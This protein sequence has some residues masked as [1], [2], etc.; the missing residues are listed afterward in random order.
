MFLKLRK[1]TYSPLNQITIS[2]KAIIDNYKHVQLLNPNIEIFPVLKSN[3]YG[4]G[5]DMIGDFIDE[6]NSKYICVD[7]IFE[8][9]ELLKL[10]VKTPILIL[11]YVDSSNLKRKKLPFSYAVWD[12]TQ[13][14][15]ILKYQA[16][17]KLHLFI[18]T[19]MH[20]EGVR[21]DELEFLLKE[22]NGYQ[23]NFEGLM[24]HFAS[25]DSIDSNLTQQ[26]LE[27]FEKAISLAKNLGFNFKY[28]HI[29]ASAGNLRS[30]NQEFNASRL[31]ISLYG[32]DILDNNHKLKP[33]LTLTSTLVQIKRIKVGET[34]GYNG[35][36]TADKDMIIGIL[37]IGYNDGVDR[38]LSSK[39][40]VKIHGKFCK[41]IGRISMN[42]TSI[43]I[44]DIENI[45]VGDQVVIYS[46][47]NNDLNSV[48]NVAKVCQTIPYEI[49]VHLDT[50][51]NRILV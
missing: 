21:S 36:F 25:A 50:S 47:E 3:A 8:A 16:Q 44:T 17:A 11:G 35:T 37:P 13:I 51:I 10:N 5:I 4:H 41:I 42:I 15:E 18:D 40:Y 32:F 12:K 2:K 20:R 30:L 46:A 14:V 29:S 31:G 48:N 49:L 43:D 19:G 1:N 38:R 33:A 23:N 22:I 7:S 6:L 45:K 28:K 26:Q 39:G 24:S 34:I 9:Y 27:S